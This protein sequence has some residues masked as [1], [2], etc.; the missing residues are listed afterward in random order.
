MSDYKPP[1]GANTPGIEAPIVAP[2]SYADPPGLREELALLLQDIADFMQEL[3]EDLLDYALLIDP[4]DEKLVDA[5]EY[6]LPTG[7]EDNRRVSYRFYKG[8]R[9]RRTGSAEYIR[10]RYEE[11]AR[12]VTG[13][14]AL[15]YVKLLEIMRNEALRVQHF[16]D[17]YIQEA[18]DS[19]ELRT[20]E[21]FQDW[22]VAARGYVV[23]FRRNYTEGSIAPSQ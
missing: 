19:S 18:D 6:E 20:I 23:E 4:D 2:A 1:I 7:F 14:T 21:V 13:T 10:K 15:D 5:Y 11:A 17:T 16:L 9:F 8:L 22:V 12:D 3:E